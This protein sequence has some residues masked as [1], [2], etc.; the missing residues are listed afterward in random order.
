VSKLQAELDT[1]G[2]ASSAL[3]L[4]L[5]G[6][7]RENKRLRN[8][9]HYC[10]YCYQCYCYCTIV[11]CSVVLCKAAHT[12]L[13]TDRPS[14]VL[15]LQITSSTAQRV[16]TTQLLIV[17]SL[18][19]QSLGATIT[20]VHTQVQ[21]LGGRTVVRNSAELKAQ[22]FAL[23]GTSS[24][25][26]SSSTTSGNSAATATS[27]GALGAGRTEQFTVTQQQRA[28]VPV[29]RFGSSRRQRQEAKLQQLEQEQ[30]QLQQQF[31]A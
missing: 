23:L 27:R 1:A 8:E 22:L 31:A 13:H 14:L 26:R 29:S 5:D 15:L 21:R 12:A 7:E 16:P 20:V 25:S 19:L 30:Q 2:A 4:K 6:L 18:A 9:V 24:S 3:L 28:A 11:H 10:Y 17:V